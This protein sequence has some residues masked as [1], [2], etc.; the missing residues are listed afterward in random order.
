M[1]SKILIIFILLLTS[2]VKSNE[3]EVIELHSNK[4]LDEM[5]L[6]KVNK[7]SNENEQVE[8]KD[9]N[10]NKNISSDNVEQT[11]E[12]LEIL[13]TPSFWEELDL[14]ELEFYLNN[15]NNIKSQ[16]IHNEFTANLANDNFDYSKQKN[17]DIFFLIIKNF[18]ENG[19]IN[20]AYELISTR[21]YN[22]N[23]NLN[24]YKLVE[25]NYLLSTFQLEK[26][27][28][29][30]DILDL[31]FDLEFNLL[32]KI[33]IFC[34]ILQNKILEA[35]LQNSIML[36]TTDELDDNF[37]QLYQFLI[38]NNDNINLN[39]M[40][41]D[42]DY[43][44]HSIFL[45]S[46]MSRIGDIPLNDDFFDIDPNNLAIPVILNSATNITTRLKAANK[47][48]LNEIITVDS[49]AALYQSVDFNSKQLTNSEDT[50]KNISKNVEMSMAFYYQLTNIQ[51]FPSDR[52]KVLIEFWNFAKENNLEKIAYQLTTKI[53]S[54][55]ELNSS[56]A[57]HGA[58]IAL[59]Y[60]YNQQYEEAK[61]WNDLYDSIFGIDD[62][63][64]YVNLLLDLYKT[65]DIQPVVDFI[66]SNYSE[67]NKLNDK[68][69]KELI[70][71]L[72]SVFN[73]E[74]ENLIQFDYDEIFDDRKMPSLIVN[75]AIYSALKSNEEYKFL[76]LVAS[77][78][79]NLEW[80]EIHPEHLKIIL[81]GFS[82]Y[83]DGVL[84][85]PLILEIF[86]SYKI[87]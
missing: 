18:Y 50:L 41:F 46:A 31:E 86:K 43:S 67:I 68:K 80:K 29:N 10:E 16:T 57:I 22:E 20:K 54:S 74:N 12:T 32:N 44:K 65:D 62:K 76:F 77:S 78:I 79:N 37:Q 36:E 49:L 83:R 28:E 66:V 38:G 2:L 59:S 24:F 84:I 61:E 58:E 70:I 87:L 48:F 5:V 71:L 14:I 21:N 69:T 9:D 52:L 17:K 30:K 56:N 64:T 45:Y 35:E 40:N 13:E 39:S 60:I 3:I 1:I 81:N 75:N 85:K 34:L 7:N 15:S 26:L 19:E 51:I 11:S 55:I 47:A 8:N 4:S 25:F 63:S 33:D 23:D 53:I 82:N 73:K 42:N 27:C 72:L 6:E